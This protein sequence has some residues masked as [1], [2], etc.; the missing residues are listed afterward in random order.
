MP[1]DFPDS[2]TTNDTYTFGGVTWKYDG[3]KWRLL[4]GSSVPQFVSTLPT[5]PVDGQ[6]IYYAANATDGVIWHLRYRSGAS[7]DY[8]WEYLGG[9][10]L[11]IYSGANPS[12]S[13]SANTWS[14]ISTPQEISVPLAG[15]HV[16]RYSTQTYRIGAS[17]TTYTGL[18]AGSTEPTVDTN[19]AYTNVGADTWGPTAQIRRLDGL[20][21]PD[22]IIL[23]F[24]SQISAT[25]F[26]YNTS[27]EI[28]PIR[29]G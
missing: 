23:R 5:S 20:T 1:L 27:L 14:H 26:R 18:R 9:A 2:P 13:L 3:A 19:T 24:R 25:I 11:S 15:D 21:P 8:K 7:G 6:E 29:V 17:Q 12:A 4:A 10:S 28:R 22:K 16:A